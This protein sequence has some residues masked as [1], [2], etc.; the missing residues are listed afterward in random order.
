MVHSFSKPGNSGILFKFLHETLWHELLVNDM[1]TRKS[2]QET[3]LVNCLIVF[4]LWLFKR[5]E[6]NFETNFGPRCSPSGNRGPWENLGPQVF[7]LLKLCARSFQLSHRNDCFP[8]YAF[9]PTENCPSTKETQITIGT[10]SVS[11]AA[12]ETNSNPIQWQ[13]ISLPSVPLVPNPCFSE[14]FYQDHCTEL[15]TQ[16]LQS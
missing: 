3:K 6:E 5:K 9:S 14:R 1:E 8:D 11:N 16:I 2:L 13:F 10:D 4:C 7:F 15:M 12:R